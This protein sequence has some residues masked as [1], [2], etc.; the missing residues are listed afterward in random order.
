MVAQV[1]GA[2][3][4]QAGIAGDA[5][6]H[7][8]IAALGV[9]RILLHRDPCG[10]GR[11]AARGSRS[12]GSATQCRASCRREANRSAG[13]IGAGEAAA[14][15][16]PDRLFVIAA[17]VGRGPGVARGLECI[18]GAPACCISS[19]SRAQPLPFAGFSR[20]KKAMTVDGFSPGRIAFSAQLRMRDA[21]GQSGLAIRKRG[22]IGEAVAAALAKRRHWSSE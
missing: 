9:R 16:R 5:A 8:M 15:A 6:D 12:R 13:R 20:A 7:R 10:E 21:S 19:A 4:H 17:E 3:H 1:A 18:G 11:P 2:V 14:V 22:V